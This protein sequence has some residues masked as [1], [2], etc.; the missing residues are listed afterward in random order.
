[1]KVAD[2]MTRDREHAASRALGG[3]AEAEA[4]DAT[5]RL[6]AEATEIGTSPQPPGQ[7]AQAR[8]EDRGAGAE[9]RAGGID[10]FRDGGGDEDERR[11]ASDCS[12]ERSPAFAPPALRRGCRPRSR[13]ASSAG[14]LSLSLMLAGQQAALR[15]PRD[16][17]RSVHQ[18]HTIA[19]TIA[20]AAPASERRA[21]T[22]AA[23]ARVV[24]TA[25]DHHVR[26]PGHHQRAVADRAGGADRAA[27]DREHQ[28]FG[29]EQP[30]H[31]RRA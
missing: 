6:T 4:G 13:F 24:P 17:P 21:A 18:M 23:S 27:G 5:G 12:A 22:R 8:D 30:A 25:P 15:D 1:M 3:V 14:K 26:R 9:E 2:A 20:P 19:A 16:R 10:R 31:A 7:Q 29:G 11:A 28:P